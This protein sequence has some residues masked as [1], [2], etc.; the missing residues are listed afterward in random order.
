MSEHTPTPWR[1]HNRTAIIGGG[2]H[3]FI[4]DLQ[5]STNSAVAD[6]D[7]AHIVRCVNAHDAL[8]ARVAELEAQNAVLREALE[9]LHAA[10]G[11]S[12]WINITPK[13]S[14]RQERIDIMNAARAALA[15]D[16]G[17]G[18]SA[19]QAVAELSKAKVAP[20][21]VIAF[22]SLIPVQNLMTPRERDMANALINQW[23]ALRSA[24]AKEGK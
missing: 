16:K 24:S 13:P 12:G 5:R 19:L 9:K 22:L 3:G 21:W 14:E 23:S 4:G 17:E 10:V 20:A 8:T 2:R 6:A 1:V 7:A 18:K 15:L 11:K